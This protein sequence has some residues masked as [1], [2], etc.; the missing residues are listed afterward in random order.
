MTGRDSLR[1]RFE[2]CDVDASV[3]SARMRGGARGSVV[4]Y[5]VVVSLRGVALRRTASIVADRLKG[6]PASSFALRRR[7][8]DV[9]QALLLL[10]GAST[11]PASLAARP[12]AGSAAAAGG[13][14]GSARL[15]PR[16]VSA[17]PSVHAAGAAHMA[18]ADTMHFAVCRR[19]SEFAKLDAGIRAMLTRPYGL[20]GR[21]AAE[22]LAQGSSKRKAT[23]RRAAETAAARA[24][25]RLPALPPRTWWRTTEPGF[26]SRRRAALA[27]YLSG[28]LKQVVGRSPMAPGFNATPELDAIFL[29]PKPR[30]DDLGM[31]PCFARFLSCVIRGAHSSRRPRGYVRGL[32]RASLERMLEE[33]VLPPG[34]VALADG[35]MSTGTRSAIGAVP[36]AFMDGG[37]H[38]L[39]PLAEEEDG[40]TAQ[41]HRPARL[42]AP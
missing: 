35:A 18:V 6:V 16:A 36:A 38:L 37:G 10:T 39:E 33:A 14:R 9:Q 40:D 41:S 4:E 26:V 25:A 31:V 24:L 29:E 32:A 20:V 30:P 27:E 17:D 8:D 21:E 13:E 34:A 42:R 3:T 22:V 7:P 15:A 28:L 11:L 19:Y 12:R 1:E 2:M 5:I 23:I